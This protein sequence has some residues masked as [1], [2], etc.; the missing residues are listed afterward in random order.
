MKKFNLLLTGLGLTLFSFAQEEAKTEEFKPYGNMLGKVHANF[1]YD[2]TEDANHSAFEL[3]KGYFG[4]KHN[5]TQKVSGKVMMD[6]GQ[7]DLSVYTA[8]LKNAYI[9][10]KTTDKL[11]I[12]FGLAGTK[13]WKTQ[14]KHWGYRYVAKTIQ[15]KNKFGSSADMGIYFDYKL[16]D[17]IQLDLSMNNGEGYKKAQD[18]DGDY[19]YSAGLTLAPIKGVTIRGYYD[20]VTIPS[21]GDSL[22]GFKESQSTIAAFIGYK[23]E[24]F[25]IG[26]EYN[27]QTNHK[28][29]L[30]NDLAGFSGY[31]TVVISKKLEI[32]GRYDLLSSVK[33]NSTDMNNWNN[34]KDG[35]AIIGGLH[36]KPAKNISVSLNY[37]GWTPEQGRM[38]DADPVTSLPNEVDTEYLETPMVYLSL[39]FKF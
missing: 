22:T 12:T 11:T 31:L 8:F 17:V 38:I 2:F 33:I 16:N 37:Q 1:H 25:R 19:K 26:A 13:Q 34:G 32:F 29:N 9:Q 10:W 35:A 23:H 4:Y 28:N 20:I 18:A 7:D 27:I 6:V 21:K 30:G 39:E 14:E 24:K 36:Y 5:F 15:D 3:T